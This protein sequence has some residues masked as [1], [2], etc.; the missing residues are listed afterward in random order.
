ML[1]RCC[2][3]LLDVNT[4]HTGDIKDFGATGFGQFSRAG[5]DGFRVQGVAFIQGDDFRLA[6]KN[7]GVVFKLLADGGVGRAGGFLGCR[8]PNE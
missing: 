1:K 4:G 3:Q 2:H 6:F 7:I 5:F 8:P